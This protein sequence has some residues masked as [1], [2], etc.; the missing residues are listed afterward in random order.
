MWLTFVSTATIR[1]FDRSIT[2]IVACG[3]DKRQLLQSRA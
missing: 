2:T 1:D 3:S